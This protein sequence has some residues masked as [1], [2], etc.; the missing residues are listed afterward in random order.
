MYSCDISH[1]RRGK[2]ACTITRFITWCLCK[3]IM[4]DRFRWCTCVLL[5]SWPILAI[6]CHLLCIMD[7]ASTAQWR[8]VPSTFDCLTLFQFALYHSYT[9]SSCPAGISLFITVAGFI[10][11]FVAL[12]IYERNTWSHQLLVQYVTAWS[13]LL[14]YKMEFF[15]ETFQRVHFAFGIIVVL[16]QIINVSFLDS[17]WLI[18]VLQHIH[19]LADHLQSFAVSLNLP[20]E[21]YWNFSVTSFYFDKLVQ[22]LDILILPMPR[23]L[24][25]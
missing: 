1:S 12:A 15:L 9:D 5:I 7:E 8:V 10:F 25:L 21:W 3:R 11:A 2:N 20:S 16:F 24:D 18:N 17:S 4:W 19:I 23:L 14:K 22:P 13:H 6:F